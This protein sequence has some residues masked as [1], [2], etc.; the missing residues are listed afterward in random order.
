MGEDIDKPA[1]SV[2]IPTTGRDT[3]LPAVQS[4]LDA[5]DSERIE[6]IVAGEIPGGRMLEAI[7]SLVVRD[8]RVRHLEV[9]Y[10]TGDSSRKKNDGLEAAGAEFVAFIDDDV[11]V[12]RDWPARILE[13]FTDESVGLV[14]GPAMVPDEL[15]LAGRLAGWSL[16][17]KASGYSRERLVRGRGQIRTVKWS[18]IIGCNMAYRKSVLTGIGGFHLQFWPGE[19]MLAS[20]QAEKAGHALKFHPE[21]ILHHYPRSTVSGF[22]K[23]IYGYG[24]TRIRLIR[25]GVEV[26]PATLVPFFFVLSLLALVLALV[27]VPVLMWVLGAEL[28][29][30]SLYVAYCTMDVVRRSRRLSC[31]LVFCFIPLMHLSY[32]V[33]SGAELIFPN[34]DLSANRCE[35][36]T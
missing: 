29:L 11:V 16:L 3:L 5:R 21:A 25:A 8:P 15:P 28:L 24:A 35:G 2:V 20:Y 31:L 10:A 18:R 14:G 33:G 36:C 6:V 27:F 26:E 30:Y 23:Q 12:S 17:S 7:R 1:L 32:G 34:R 9:S 13:A 19:E 22:W 4:V